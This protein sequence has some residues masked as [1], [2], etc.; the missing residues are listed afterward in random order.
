MTKEFQFTKKQQAAYD[1]C[2]K[3]QRNVV[4][5]M[6]NTK[7]SQ[8]AAYYEAG[9]KAKTH[10]S[11]DVN[12]SKMLALAKVK[13]F[14][15]LLIEQQAGS[16]IMTRE[17]ILIRLSGI[18][19]TSIT[20]IIDFQNIELSRQEEKSTGKRQS[21]WHIRDV[22]SISPEHAASIS[23]VTAGKEGLKIKMRCPIAAMKNISDMEGYALPTKHALTDPDGK[24]IEVIV[25]DED[26]AIKLAFLLT[27]GIKSFQLLQ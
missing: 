21:I 13:D 3:M 18:G 11:A 27:K 12:V 1:K 20:D 14:Y 17:E 7:M 10:K 15:D 16:A 25:T 26:R 23:E 4:I 2:T 9:G 19:R 24:A 5:N 6:V 22:D 8:R